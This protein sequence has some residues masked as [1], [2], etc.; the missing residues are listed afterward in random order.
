MFGG[1]GVQ[2]GG[3]RDRGDEAEGGRGELQGADGDQR[4][5]EQAQE[6]RGKNV[7]FGQNIS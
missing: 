2:A 4:A 3:G 1:R 5:R 6:T 7:R